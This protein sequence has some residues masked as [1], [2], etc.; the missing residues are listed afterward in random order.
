MRLLVLYGFV[1]QSQININCFKRIV[2][3]IEMKVVSNKTFLVNLDFKLSP[4]FESIMYFLGVSPASDCC[5]PT[6]QN[7]LSVPSSRAGCKV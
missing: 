3:C 4:C 2:L 7:P 1:T 5:M 6:F